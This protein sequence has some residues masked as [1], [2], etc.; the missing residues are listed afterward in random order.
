M[1]LFF[2]TVLT[3]LLALSLF[4]GCETTKNIKGSITSTVDSITSDVDQDLFAQVPEDQLEGVQKAE[5]DLLVL[6]EKVKFA[7]LKNEFAKKQK[8]YASYEMDLVKKNK[9]EASLKLDVEKI[10]AIDRSDLGKKQDNLKAIADL[11][12]KILD[13]ESDKAKIEGKLFTTQIDIEN[14]RKQIEEM[15]EMIKNMKMVKE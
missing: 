13:I 7:E 4:V 1:R 10:E 14:L 12:A 9:R 8:K 3:I 6:K 15:E 2:H 5:F 11:K